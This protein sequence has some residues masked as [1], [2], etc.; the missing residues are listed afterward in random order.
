MSTKHV[1]VTSYNPIW[2]QIFEAEAAKIK[3]ALGDNCLAI[4]HIGSTSIP[5]LDAKEDIDI[6]L[7][8]R[9]LQDSL[10]NYVFKGE[11]N[12]PFRY[13]FNKNAMD[14]KVNL[15]MVEADHGFLALNLCFTTY[16][17]SHDDVRLAYAAFKHDLLKN[18]ESYTRNESRFSGYTL[19]KYQFI[20][21]VLDQAGFNHIRFMHC[22]HPVEWE[23]ARL[24]RQKY[25]F[26]KIPID[27]PYTW[28][29]NH[30]DHVHLVLYQGTKIIG[31]AHIQLWPDNRS[32]LRIIVIDED[33]RS[34]GFGTR[35]LAFIE[36]WL[37]AKARKS[38]HIES[39]PEALAFYARLNYAQMPFNDPDGNEGF[40][41]DI[42]IGKHF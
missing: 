14:S 9:N 15:H 20:N 24:Y 6:C 31:Y 35:F 1:E 18:P 40:A 37:K 26:G 17:R 5:G 16:L 28:T 8:V 29:F 3:K 36:K 34:R 7:V 33:N 23:A 2:P 39:S 21:N 25:F 42:P 32:A 27:D 12:I 22:M 10:E 41:Q 4:H 13:F 11:L 38:L 19:G 30:P